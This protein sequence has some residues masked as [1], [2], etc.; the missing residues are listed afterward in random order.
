MSIVNHALHHNNG[1]FGDDADEY[2][3]ELWNDPAQAAEFERFLIPFS[4]VTGAALTKSISTINN[5]N[6]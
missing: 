3:H 1:I 4:V 6:Q 5:F 2:I